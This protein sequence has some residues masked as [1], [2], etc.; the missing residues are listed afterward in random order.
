MI[1][2]IIINGPTGC[3]NVF[4]QHLI[5]VN[6][7]AQVVWKNHDIL[8]FDPEEINLFPLRDPYSAIPSGIEVRLGNLKE[9]E[10]SDFNA[11]FEFAMK[12][13]IIRHMATYLQFLNKVDY[14]DYITPV[15]FDFFTQ[16]PE[17]F[18]M[19]LHK[20]FNIPF[21]DPERRLSGEEIKKR[22]AESDNIEI[23]NRV[24]R[25]KSLDR[26][27]LDMLVHNYEPIEYL[28]KQYS[29][30]REI[31]R[32]GENMLCLDNDM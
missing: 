2:K 20:N 3:G 12:E 26:K 30:R 29:I 21:K 8:G 4:L 24:P 1:K 25:E 27:K 28:H 19:Y 10:R 18:L 14:Y 11:D 7:V 13:K 32:L 31:L 9:W 17:K 23:N 22:I 5:N 6:M 16:E 15:A